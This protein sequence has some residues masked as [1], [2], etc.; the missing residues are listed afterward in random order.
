MFQQKMFLDVIDVSGAG[1]AFIAGR[2]YGLQHDKDVLEACQIGAKA[3]AKT[4][5]SINTVV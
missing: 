4:I 3:A 1:D 5:Q 2:L